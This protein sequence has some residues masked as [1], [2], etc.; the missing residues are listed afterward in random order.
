MHKDSFQAYKQFEFL[1]AG[2]KT[3][4]EKQADELKL[5]YSSGGFDPYDYPPV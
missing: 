3:P 2:I 5:K 4:S 1:K